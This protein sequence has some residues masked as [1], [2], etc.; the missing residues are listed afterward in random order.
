MMTNKEIAVEILLQF[1][2]GK[3]PDYEHDHPS[4]PPEWGNDTV[5]ALCAELK[6]ARALLGRAEDALLADEVE[7]RDD[8]LLPAIRQALGGGAS[9]TIAEIC[10]IDSIV[11]A[12]KITGTNEAD[13]RFALDQ[14]RRALERPPIID[15]DDAIDAAYLSGKAAARCEQLEEAGRR[16]AELERQRAIVTL[17]RI[18]GNHGDNDWPDNLHLAD[19]LEKHLEKH[20]E[21]HLEDREAT[22]EPWTSATRAAIDALTSA[23]A[24]ETNAEECG[25]PD[26]NRYRGAASTARAAVDALVADQALEVVRL[27]CTLDGLVDHAARCPVSYRTNDAGELVLWIPDDRPPRG[28]QLWLRELDELLGRPTNKPAEPAAGGA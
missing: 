16:G 28:L 25:W 20:L 17:R 8:S 10:A 26:P 14:L 15:R 11:K 22:A 4:H 9:E 21:R 3:I 12:A 2:E 23:I 7:N 24:N 5:H 19:V 13:V 1:D 27:A 18:C 6:E